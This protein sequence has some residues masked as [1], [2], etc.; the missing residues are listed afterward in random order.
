MMP[1]KAD[2]TGRVWIETQNKHAETLHLDE[3]PWGNSR[4]LDMGRPPINI[5]ARR[6]GAGGSGKIYRLRMERPSDWKPVRDPTIS[7]GLSSG[8]I[9]E[10]LFY[11]AEFWREK[12]V[13]FQCMT[14]QNG[15]VF[16]NSLLFGG[17]F[18]KNL[19]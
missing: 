1:K 7:F 12:E 13:P 16:D 9:N 15:A 14:N 5:A 10:T 2:G 19:S 4:P 18:L 3:L 17:Q 11:L 8:H 6:R